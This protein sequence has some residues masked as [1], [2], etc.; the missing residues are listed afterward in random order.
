LA[1]RH[2]LNA[3]R[4]D[5]SRDYM[6]SQ[7][8]AEVA[9]SSGFPR[10]K[11]WRKPREFLPY[12]QLEAEEKSERGVSARKPRMTKARKQALA[13]QFRSTFMHFVQR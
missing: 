4:S 8:A 11:D 12:W 10:Y 13:D 9:N 5:R 6:L 2:K 3:E 1:K 7:I